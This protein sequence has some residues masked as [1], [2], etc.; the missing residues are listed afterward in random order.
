MT[1]NCMLSHRLISYLYI[2]SL[3]G[4]FKGHLVQPHPCNEQG[5]LHLDQVAQSPILFD[6][7][8]LQG[9]GIYHLSG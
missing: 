4:T 9:W 3:E 2:Q 1:N 6:L 8:Y 5:H 7:E